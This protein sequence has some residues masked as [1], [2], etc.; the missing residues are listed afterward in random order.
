MEKSIYSISFSVINARLNAGIGTKF[1]SNEV[2]REIIQKGGILRVNVGVTI[3]DY[4]ECLYGIGFLE[5][6]N[7]EEELIYEVVARNIEDAI[8]IE[9]KRTYHHHFPPKHDDILF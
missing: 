3:K 2:S 5:I 7:G 8:S 6:T 1:T 9:S 4:L